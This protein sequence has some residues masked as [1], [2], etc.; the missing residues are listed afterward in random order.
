MG[1]H[2]GWLHVTRA[3]LKFV[4]GLT[5]SGPSHKCWG[6]LQGTSITLYEEQVRGQP[7]PSPPSPGPTALTLTL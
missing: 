5:A 6:V 4:G 3:T 2:A 7:S 1:E